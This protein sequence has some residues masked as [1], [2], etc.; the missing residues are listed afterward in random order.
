[1]VQYTNIQVAVIYS[2]AYG[3]MRGDQI[4]GQAMNLHNN[5]QKVLSGKLI[6]LFRFID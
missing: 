6:G 2:M 5:K 4:I 1:M 3:L